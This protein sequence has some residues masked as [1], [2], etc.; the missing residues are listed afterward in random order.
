MEEIDDQEVPQAISTGDEPP[1]AQAVGQ[2]REVLRRAQGT[3][4][5]RKITESRDEVL[6]RFQPMFRP[7]YITS[8][9]AEEFRPFF[10]FKHNLHWTG[11]DRQVNRVC[12]NMSGVREVLL[13]L[14]NETRPIE[15]RLDKIVGVV[16][17]M[18]KAIITAILT[19]AFPAEYGV[20]NG[21]SEAGLKKL[22][23][24]PD[25]RGLSLGKSYRLVND[26]LGKLAAALGLDF[27]TLDA[28]WWQLDGGDDTDIRSKI[29]RQDVSDAIAAL[30]SGEPHEFGPSVFYDLLEGGRRY[31]P[32]AVIGLAARRAMGRP[33]RPDEFSGGQESWAFRRLRE[34]G[35]TIVGKERRVGSY[36]FP[37]AP[38]SRVWIEGA[39]TADHG[40][41]GWEFGACLWSPS[42]YKNGS[43]HYALMRQPV[44]D[45]LVI[46]INSGI[47]AGWSFVSAPF[48]E[49]TEEPPEPGSYAGRSP[50][51]RIDLKEYQ[52]FP[53][54]LP[55]TE[56]IEEHGTLIKEELEHDRP[57]RYP[58]ILYGDKKIV[59]PAQGAYLT[60]CTP[61]LFGLIRSVIF[62]A[63]SVKDARYWAMGFGEG[64]RL[65]DEC[66]E[67]GIA[68]IGWDEY[69]LG[70]LTQYPDKETIQQL[71]I[72]R[73][74]APGPTPNN[75]ALCLFQFSHEVAVGDYIMA[76]VGRRRLLGVGVVTSNYFLDDKRTEYQHC[77]RVKWLI[78]QSIELP[79]NLALTTKTLTDVTAVLDLVAFVRDRYFEHVPPSAKAVLP[80]YSIDQALEELFIPRLQL[81][82]ILVA[83]RRKKNVIL[84]GPPGVGKTFTARHIA[85]A[86]LQQI[87]PT[88][89]EMVQFHQSYSYEDFVQGWR[90]SVDG[91]FRLRNG[92]FLE[93]CNRARIDP[94][95]AYVFII[96]EINRGNLRVRPETS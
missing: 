73:R 27:W 53:T 21:I 82:Q 4:S 5:Y 20:W 22:G 70:D 26:V 81:E 29:T 18:G 11:L 34:L 38:P 66:Q 60:R 87:D 49:V 48:R 58:F 24:F 71:L 62:G 36:A 88:R 31:P 84:Q 28:L 1:T 40:G 30:D 69:K 2:L 65:W 56:F 25:L 78:S 6:A 23:V 52:T 43:D 46:H 17:G 41:T 44:T 85:F 92:V 42:T 19:V 9:T 8:L 74:G 59:R 61:K 79:E 93:F 7:S 96:D 80:G 12:S 37:D 94:D 57:K 14:M 95:R 13:E 54:Q 63:G 76:K 86:L 32:K 15:E 89:V 83:L 67:K 39:M 33:L 35:Y 68:A 3:E 55:L 72:E 10:S 51:Y 90:P 16:P 45:D 75:D 47:L 64:G 77:H 50:Y 91:G